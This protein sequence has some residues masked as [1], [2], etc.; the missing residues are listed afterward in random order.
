MIFEPKQIEEMELTFSRGFSPGWLN[1]C[2]HKMLVPGTSSAKRGVLLGQVCGISKD[3]IAVEL[4]ASV[5][6]G[7]GVAFDTSADAAT[8][9]AESMRCFIRAVHSQSL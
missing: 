9:G 2:D 4:N 5:K 3:G 6:R 7:D 8:Q 1:G